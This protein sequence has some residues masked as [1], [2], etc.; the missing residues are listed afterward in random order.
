M[1]LAWAALMVP[2][3]EVGATAITQAAPARPELRP[4]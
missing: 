4:R 1:P 3:I 2:A